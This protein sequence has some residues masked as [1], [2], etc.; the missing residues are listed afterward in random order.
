MT[1]L[2][3][4]I[5]A[6]YHRRNG[7]RTPYSTG[8]PAPPGGD[9]IMKNRPYYVLNEVMYLWHDYS[10]ESLATVEALVPWLY[11]VYTRG[12]VGQDTEPQKPRF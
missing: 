1:F 7:C 8:C 12:T 10:R 5:S 3:K 11:F 4:T 6:G 9:L 2:L